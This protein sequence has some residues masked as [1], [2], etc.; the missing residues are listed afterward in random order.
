MERVA[1]L[2]EPG[3]QRLACLLNPE[4]VVMRRHA[5]VRR[6][7]SVGGPLTGAG[8]SDDPLLYTGGGLTELRLDLLFDVSVA[9]STVTSEDVREL[10]G[11]FW[12]MAENSGGDE[13]GGVDG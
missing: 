3:G 12:R 7:R 5:G 8:L 6:R 2:I 10:T 13:A 9:G 11:P 4:T 1:F